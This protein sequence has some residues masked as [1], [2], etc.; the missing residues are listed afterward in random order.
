MKY[1]KALVA[2]ALVGVVTYPLTFAKTLIQLG[3]EPYSLSTG[4]VF[5][6]A[7]REAYFLPNAFKYSKFFWN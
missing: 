7:G 1:S 6:V 4:R 5:I 2:K 3:Y